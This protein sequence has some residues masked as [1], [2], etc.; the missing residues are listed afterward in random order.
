MSV[1]DINIKT[2]H[3]TFFDDIINIKDFYPKNIKIDKKSHTKIFLFTML[4]MRQSK[5]T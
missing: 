2:T 1:K 4:D 5:K 3:T